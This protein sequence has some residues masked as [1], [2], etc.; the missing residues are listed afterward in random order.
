MEIRAKDCF[1]L[2]LS[3]NNHTGTFF[4]L[5]KPSSSPTFSFGEEK[6]EQEQETT[7]EQISNEKGK[8]EEPNNKEKRKRKREETDLSR[9]ERHFTFEKESDYQSLVSP[10]SFPSLLSSSA[11]FSNTSLTREGKKK[12]ELLVPSSWGKS[13]F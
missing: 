9:I 7:E 13:K 12:A 5:R 6:T 11:S 1:S 8:A 3:S 2:P 4:L 10:L